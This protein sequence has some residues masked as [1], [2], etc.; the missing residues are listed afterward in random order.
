MK[1]FKSKI[2]DNEKVQTEH[3]VLSFRVPKQVEKVK[4]GQFFNLKV[5]ELTVPLLRRPFGAHKIEKSKVKIL[6]KVVG[7]ATQILS[8]KKPDDILDIVGPLGKGFDLHL[9]FRPGKKEIA[10]L[11]AGGHGV[12][13][14]YALAH[15]LKRTKKAV[16]IGARTKAHIVCE[17]G[18]KKLGAKV[19]IATED[20][21]KG[22]K[23]FI[24]KMLNDNIQNNGYKK[25][26]IHIYACGP[27]PMLKEIAKIADKY[28]CAC[29]VSLEEYLGCGTGI[30][31]G[32]AIETRSGKK[33]VCKDGP[34]F[35]AEEILW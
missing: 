8:L 28:K 21:S 4:P 31:I 20:G 34:V 33:L 3:Y 22:D 17:Q 32:C 11:V 14:L 15:S 35:N 1:K 5:N 2:I 26:T 30:C 9:P 25:G 24:T 13:P 19:Y 29:Q 10:I 23:G 12:A 18:F 16:F 7:K 6:Y 27:K